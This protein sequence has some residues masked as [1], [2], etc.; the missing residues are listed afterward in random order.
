MR[1]PPGAEPED[2][3]GFEDEATAVL[4]AERARALLE[5]QLDKQPVPPETPMAFG[6]EAQA[7]KGS[8]VA[9]TKSGSA[10]QLPAGPTKRESLRAHDDL[11]DKGP[12]IVVAASEK[13]AAPA[14]KPAPPQSSKPPPEPL[15]LAKTRA[16]DFGD[17]QHERTRVVRARRKSTGLWFWIALVV[18]LAAAAVAGYY[19][20]R[21]LDPA[22]STP[23]Q[24]R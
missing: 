17:I 18:A 19:A 5:D 22:K 9:E 4:T 6:S 2:P 20:S 10:D 21:V 23:P 11:V 13:E 1:P 24:G 16:R 7:K 8:E 3:F 14:P 12:T 15:S